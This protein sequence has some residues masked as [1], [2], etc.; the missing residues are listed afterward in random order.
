MV[1]PP[2]NI[3]PPYLLISSIPSKYSF[4]YSLECKGPNNV[5]GCKGSPTGIVLYALIKLYTSL[6]YTFLWITN[7]LKVVH[8]YPQVPTAA[9][10]DP[11]N[12]NSKLASSI[13]IV[14]LLPPN[15]KMVLP[16]LECTISLTL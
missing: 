9:N 6:L 11:F 3:F 13:T 16:N 7:L 15:S 1:L 5:S 10:K 4:T 2:S 14:A 8:L 12:T